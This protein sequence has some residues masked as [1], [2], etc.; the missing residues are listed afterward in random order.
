[1][2]AVNPALTGTKFAAWHSATVAPGQAYV[3]NLVL[4]AGEL[5]DPFDRH[6]AIT[7]ARRSEAD[8]F[9]DELLPSASPEDHRIMRQSLAGMIW[10]KQ[11]YHYDV[12]RWLDGDQLPAPPERRHGRNVGWRHVEAA[13]IISMPDCWEYPWFAAWDLAYHCAALAL[14]DVE[15]AKH[16]IELMLSERYLNPNGQIPSYEWDFGDTNPPVHA[17]G[18]LK[19]FRAERVQTGRADLDFLKRV[20][21]KLL[22]NYA[23]WI[24]RKDREGHNLFEG[25]FLGLDNISVYD[26]SKP[27]PPGFTLKQADATGWM[28]MFAVQ[29]TVMALELAVEDANYEDMAIQIYDQFLAIANAIA[30]GDDHGVSLWHD[31]AGFFTDVLVTPEGTTHRIDVYSWVGLIPLF[32]CEVIDQRLLANAPRFRE[33]LLKHKKGLFRGHEICACPNWE[34]ERGEHLL[35]L[36]NETM[37]PRILAHLLSEDEFLS[38]YGVRGVSRI[39]AEV[40][41][42]GHLPGIGDVTI[43]YIPGESTSD[44]FG[45]NSNWRGP[46]WMPTNFTLVQALEKYHRYLGDGFRVPVPFLDNEELNLQQIATLIAE[47]L[48]DLY[49]RD[50]NGHVPALRGGSPFQDDPNW[51]D[52]CFFYEYFHADTG[53]GL[54]AAHQTGW[55][56]LL[57][58][59]VM[60]RHRKHIPAFWRDKD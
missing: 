15:F 9:Y 26:R 10:S 38:R 6:G 45:G 53:Q 58:N 43:E 39:H 24:N 59:L 3:L 54:G 56:G 35:A 12:Q 13:D 37:L 27:L 14:I 40:Q 31:E 22:L 20:F 36:V 25:G 1:A 41:D 8:V 4:S 21:N 44:L 50:E 32:G 28:A 46:V 34:N 23:W 5:D 29:M 16:Q 52:L 2:A 55:T 48:V 33:L 7:A 47:R 17:A 18:A 42:L 57:A 11:F 30:G 60:R 19:V 51:Q 49:R